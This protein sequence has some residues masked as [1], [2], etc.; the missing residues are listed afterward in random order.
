MAK[1]TS[2]LKSMPWC[3]GKPV[4]PGIRRRAYIVAKADVAT[5]P[6]LERDELGRPTTATYKGSF[7]LV[8]GKKWL[9]IDHLPDKAEPKSDPQG[10]FPSQTFNNQLTL[11]HPDVGPEATA[12]ISPFLNSECI[13]LVEDMYGRF[14]CFGNVDWGARVAPAQALG[15][16][17]TGTSSTTLTVT[18]S[19]ECSMPFYE[20]EIPTEDGT[21][22]EAAP[23]APSV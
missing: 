21:I 14:R 13:V 23:S 5:F 16:G 19:D 7:T 10:E 3:E 12:A 17:A 6:T 8:E 9:V 20:G 22:N 1:C 18:A 15:Q 2:I 4:K 11:V